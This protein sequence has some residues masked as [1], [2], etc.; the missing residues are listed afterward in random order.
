MSS[1]QKTERHAENLYQRTSAGLTPCG[2][3]CLWQQMYYNTQVRKVKHYFYKNLHFY[4]KMEAFSF[5]KA[6]KHL[7]PGFAVH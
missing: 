1:C 5:F 3:C 7:L 6:R 2:T 4:M